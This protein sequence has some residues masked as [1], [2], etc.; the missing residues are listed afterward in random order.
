MPFR[1]QRGL[2]DGLRIA[3]MYTHAWTDGWLHAGLDDP[4]GRPQCPVER[5]EPAHERLRESLLRATRQV[6]SP[7][8]PR[9][10]PAI[11]NTFLDG[12][13]YWAAR[14]RITCKVDAFSPSSKCLLFC[15][16][17]YGDAVL[18]SRRNERRHIIRKALK[19]T[20]KRRNDQEGLN[21]RRYSMM[22]RMVIIIAIKPNCS[23]S[24]RSTKH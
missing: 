23:F 6:S 21:S 20:A 13:L 22:R 2:S 11:L 18:W 24:G 10:Q 14:C 1:E 4:R 3:V 15:F 7:A 8:C 17:Y 9:Y 16:F 19:C 5:H 12:G